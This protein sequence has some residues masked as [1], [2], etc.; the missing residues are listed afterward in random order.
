MSRSSVKLNVGASRSKQ[1][2]NGKETI[3]LAYHEERVCFSTGNL[4][5]SS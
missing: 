2:V 4:D 3:S 1:M 5:V